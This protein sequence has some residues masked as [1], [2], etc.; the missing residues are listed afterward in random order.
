MAKKKNKK[1]EEVK[2][3]HCNGTGTA[4]KKKVNGKQ[5][6]NRGELAVAKILTEKLGLGKFNRTPN[7]GGF[8]SCHELSEEASRNLSGDLIAPIP[9]FAFS[10]ENKCG[11]DI[12]LSKLLSA[13]SNI[14]QL[15]EFLHQSCIDA[16]KT[17][18]KPM[19]I[20]TKDRRQPLAIIPIDK[21]TNDSIIKTINM[22]SFMIFNHKM[23]DFPQWNQW[24][25]LVLDE[26]LDKAPKE[27][28]LIKEEE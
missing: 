14:P 3:S 11:Y 7:S 16:A 13:K 10:I 22:K 24:I 4:I 28:F 5:K 27:F 21:D 26:L 20:Y 25:I 17:E 1:K 9:N 2:C 23:E 18:T 19:V 6:G 12:D 15:S 8:S